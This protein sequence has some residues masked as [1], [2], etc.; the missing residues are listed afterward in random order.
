M[1]KRKD[2]PFRT[3]ELPTPYYQA[4]QVARILKMDP[5]R[6]QK[7]LVGKNYRL[8]PQGRHVGK[9]QGSRRLFNRG[10]IFRLG[11]ANH[12]VKDGFSPNFVSYILQELEDAELLQMDS[13]VGFFR[14]SEKPTVGFVSHGRSMDQREQA[15]YVLHLTR[16]LAEIDDAISREA[17]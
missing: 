4:G 8:V 10:D 9:G 1:V 7:F 2:D 17:N 3:S 12:L 16:L 13:D 5:G 11:I 6:L 15:Y 14:S